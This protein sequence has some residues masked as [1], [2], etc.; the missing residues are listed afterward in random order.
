MLANAT[1]EP[2]FGWVTYDATNPPVNCHYNGDGAFT[3][4]VAGW[5]MFTFLLTLMPGTAGRRIGR[6]AFSNGGTYQWEQATVASGSTNLARAGL[7]GSMARYCP[8]GTIVTPGGYQNSGAGIAWD[9][10]ATACFF[11]ITSLAG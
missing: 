11:S 3:V 4:D 6:L 9:G 10:A 8:A 2:H 7:T 5:Y 1:W